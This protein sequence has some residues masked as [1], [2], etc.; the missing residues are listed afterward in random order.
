MRLNTA[1]VISNRIVAS[2]AADGFRQVEAAIL[3]TAIKGDVSGWIGL[4][5]TSDKELVEVN[6]VA[7]VR[8]ESLEN[9][10]RDLAG[11]P[12]FGVC[13]P[14]IS[15]HIGYLM[16]QHGYS[17]WFFD[18]ESTQRE[19]NT[20]GTCVREFALPFMQKRASLHE[21]SKALRDPTLSFR[22]QAMYRLPACYLLLADFKTS[23]AMCA[24]FLA[25]LGERRDAAAEHYRCFAEA[26]HR[27]VNQQDLQIDTV[28]RP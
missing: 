15:I 14:S 23:V 7:G 9:C 1:K 24:E 5:L 3:T 20:I 22:H 16:P 6:I 2:L 19:I 18:A 27:R 10:V 11:K 13:A 12:I 28:V 17:P 26:L 21:L 25:E 4:N 8:S